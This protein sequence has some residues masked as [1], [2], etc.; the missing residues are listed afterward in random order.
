MH[1]N[2]VCNNYEHTSEL[3]QKSMICMI[4]LGTSDHEQGHTRQMWTPQLFLHSHFEARVWQNMNEMA[5]SLSSETQWP[6][7]VSSVS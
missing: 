7:R 1:H 4:Y 5:I 2:I 6:R 3:I